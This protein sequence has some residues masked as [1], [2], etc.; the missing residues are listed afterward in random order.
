MKLGILFSGGKDS[1]LAMHIAKE[2]GYEIACLISIISE[3][4]DSF[5][6]H[7]PLINSVI[8]QAKALEIPIVLVKTKGEKEKELVDLERAIKKAVLDYGIS[9]VITGAV[10]S[11]YQASRIQKICN[12]LGIECFNPLWQRDQ[13]EI[14]EELIKRKFKVIIS[15]VFAYSLDK[16]WIGREINK[17]FINEIKKLSEKYKIN[18]AGEGGET[19]SVVLHTPMFKKELKIYDI[20]V[21]GNGNSW[22]MEGKVR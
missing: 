8:K 4:P 7:T 16:T 22:R 2:Q 18:V 1:T 13:A 20:K 15:G 21:S 17:N 19:E 10:E 12:K 3:N 6:F 14:L 9:G 11:V 5:M